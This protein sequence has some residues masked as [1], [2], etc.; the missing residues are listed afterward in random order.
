MRAKIYIALYAKGHQPSQT[1]SGGFINARLLAICW[2]FFEITE[3]YLIQSNRLLDATVAMSLRCYVRSTLTY[4]HSPLGGANKNGILGGV[5]SDRGKYRQ[6][7]H[8]SMMRTKSWGITLRFC[9]NKPNITRHQP[10]ISSSSR[11]RRRRY[12]STVCKYWNRRRNDLSPVSTLFH[13]Q[14]PL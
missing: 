9:W 2:C 6:S 5:S 11:K 14:F 3:H 12:S 1:C 13:E 10:I 7:N 8:Y 4:T